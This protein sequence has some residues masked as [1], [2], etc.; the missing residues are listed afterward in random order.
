MA[1]TKIG[2]VRQH[3][4]DSIAALAAFD[5]VKV[6]AAWDVGSRA[7]ERVYTTGAKFKQE[8]AS[9]RGSGRTYRDEAGSFE[10]ILRIEGVGKTP[11]WTID[12]AITLGTAIEE[13]VADHR[14]IA[15]D[16]PGV[17]WLVAKGDG[18]LIERFS[19]KGTL[20]QLS[21]TLAYHARL[22]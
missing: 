3:V 6:T 8:P 20:V 1:G 10:V 9:M 18:R 15:A 21:Y 17:E 4:A 16:V 13:W 14:N 2:D 7:R 19:D 5:D 22:T 11:D 12:R